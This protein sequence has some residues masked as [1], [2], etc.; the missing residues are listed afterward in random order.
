MPVYPGAPSTTSLDRVDSNC[1]RTGCSRSRR[2]SSLGVEPT[3]LRLTRQRP[4]LL[5]V[6]ATCLRSAETALFTRA[7]DRMA[8]CRRSLRSSTVSPLPFPL[9][10]ERGPGTE[11]QCDGGMDSALS[12]E[13]LIKSK[14]HFL[15]RLHCAWAIRSRPLCALR[16]WRS[17]AAECSQVLD[18][19]RIRRC[20]PLQCPAPRAR[21]ERCSHR[22]MR[23]MPASRS[24]SPAGCSPPWMP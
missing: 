8:D 22:T 13:S 4:A 9:T 16:R 14:S 1:R 3:T 12:E 19:R 5:L 24:G 18:A 20:M 10:S 6:T 21:G 7:L 17:I 11:D 2:F 23:K 15:A